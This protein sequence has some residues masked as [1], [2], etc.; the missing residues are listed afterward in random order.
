MNAAK[1]GLGN[2]VKVEDT[3]FS[4]YSDEYWD[5][6]VKPWALQ[7]IGVHELGAEA[8]ERMRPESPDLVADQLHP[9]VWEAAAPLWKAGSTQEAVHAAARSVNARLQQ[10]LDRRSI[11]DTALCREAFT[12][13]DPEQGHPRLRFPGD[14][15][16]DTWRSRQQGAMEFGAG[17]FGGI[18]NPAAH[19]DKLCLNEQ[20]ALEQL[21]AFSVLARWIHECS[22]MAAVDQ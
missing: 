18:R 16:S 20:T 12:L 3:H 15:T 4:H 11:S 7:A 10:K 22:V 6:N 5:L 13:K 17:C 2:Y 9:W 21:A 1:H 14:P 8:R 19:E